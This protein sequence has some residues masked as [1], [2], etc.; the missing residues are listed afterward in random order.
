MAQNRKQVRRKMAVSA[1]V[2]SI[3]T[4]T[5]AFVLGIS[6]DSLASRVSEMSVFLI[7]YIGGLFGVVGWYWRLGSQEDSARVESGDSPAP[8]SRVGE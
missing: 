6:S 2:A 8:G 3:A 4:G 5:A 1:F 7:P